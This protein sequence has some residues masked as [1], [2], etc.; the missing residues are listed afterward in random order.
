MVSYNGVEIVWEL[1]VLL[2]ECDRKRRRKKFVDFTQTHSKHFFC[3]LETKAKVTRFIWHNKRRWKKKYKHY[4]TPIWLCR[5]AICKVVIG[6]FCLCASVYVFY[7]MKVITRRDDF[8]KKFYQNIFEIIENDTQFFSEN[9][10][11]FEKKNSF[12]ISKV[13]SG[14][15]GFVK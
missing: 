1:C 14:M 6:L 12:S 8:L 5:N 10:T 13:S 2:M 15:G 7:L 9:K 3:A 4:W 11:F